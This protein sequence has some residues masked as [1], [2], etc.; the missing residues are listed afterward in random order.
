[1]SDT[2]STEA[3]RALLKTEMDERLALAPWASRRHVAAILAIEAQARAA[4]ERENERCH[5]AIL[6]L[7]GENERLRHIEDAALD[8]VRERFGLGLQDAV[9][10]LR[11]ALQEPTDG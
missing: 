4:A 10:H 2:P 1:M 5:N 3:G 7:T 9:D 11:A 6:A 8:V